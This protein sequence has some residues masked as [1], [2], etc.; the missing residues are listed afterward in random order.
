[1]GKALRIDRTDSRILAMVQDDCKISLEELAKRLGISKSAV[2]YRIKKL[3]NDGA[4][5]GYH[6]TLGRARLGRNYITVTLIEAK[7]GPGYHEKVGKR[8]ASIPGVCAVYYVL[9]QYDFIA[10]TRSSDNSDFM[11]KLKRM[12]KMK[13]V[14]KTRTQ[15]VAEVIKEDPRI[16]LRNPR[17]GSANMF[18]DTEG[19]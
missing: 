2:R 15:V 8:I 11:Q 12:M 3:E 9:G 5:E 7:Y 16:E 4:I 1:M 14:E 13:G 19:E 17:L 10:V 6:A 18:H